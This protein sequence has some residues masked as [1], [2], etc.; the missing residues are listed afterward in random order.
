VAVDELPS[1]HR[2]PSSTSDLVVSERAYCGGIDFV[3]PPPI[4]MSPPEGQCRLH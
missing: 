3:L 4:V 2:R 1:S